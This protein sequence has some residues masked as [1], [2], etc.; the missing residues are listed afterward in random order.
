MALRKLVNTYQN[1]YLWVYPLAEQVVVQ[2]QENLSYYRFGSK[3]QAKTFCKTCGV[4]LTN[5]PAAEITQEDVEN[6]PEPQKRRWQMINS[7]RPVNLRV[8][9]GFDL[10]G[11]NSQKWEG[12]TKIPPPYVNP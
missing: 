6:L 5:S 9:D 8:L 1:A 11:V 3:L 2:G 7:H 4:P 10:K 12:F